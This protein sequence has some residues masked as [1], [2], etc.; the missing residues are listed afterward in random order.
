[1]T[2]ITQ[3][4]QKA[5]VSVKTVSRVMNDHENVSAKMRDRV[6]RAIAE[7][8]YAPN[9]MA[10]QMRLGDAKGI[11]MLYSDPGGGYQSNLNHAVLK[12]CADTGRYLVTELFDEKNADWLRQVDDFI[13]R[14]HVR[15]LILLPPM[16]DSSEL[17]RLLKER[18]VQFVMISP[19]RNVHGVSS[20]AMD[21]RLAAYEMT[22]YLI[23]R[24]HRRIGHISGDTQHIATFLRRQGFEEAMQ[25]AG[26][27]QPGNAP[28]CEGKFRFKH[29]MHCAESML[30]EDDRPTA[31]FAANDEMAAACLMVANRLGLKI[32][33]DLSIAG[34]DNTPIAST[35]WPELTTVA[36]PFFDIARH[37][38]RLA[39]LATGKS[40]DSKTGDSGE[41]CIVPHILVTR[42]S[43]GPAKLLA[44]IPPAL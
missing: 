14:T 23:D 17:H 44:A 33:D 26:L 42:R 12:A 24:G 4:A 43:T 5:G 19:S 11:G 40:G 21:D 34:F 15:N 39:T 3:V 10:R 1:M 6:E 25:N 28:V 13:D 9:M 38:V 8:N 29:A 41:I 31:V 37:A 35:I 22:Q 30:A 36:Q 16:C 18:G 2:T 32:P 27:L 7:L 20:V